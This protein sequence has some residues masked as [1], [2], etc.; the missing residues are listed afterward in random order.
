MIRTIPLIQS[1]VKE[2]MRDWKSILLLVVLPLVLISLVFVSFNPRGLQKI[3]VGL[4]VTDKTLNTGEFR[5]VANSF[6]ITTDFDDMDTCLLSLKRYEQYACI[7][8][9]KKGAI[10]LDVY[11]DNTREPVIWELLG[12]LKEATDLIKEG[13]SKNMASDFLA[14]FNENLEKIKVFKQN[15]QETNDLLDN[16]IGQ[17]DIVKSQMTSARN[18]LTNTLNEMDSDIN[19]VKSQEND[20]R[21]QKND[22]YSRSISTINQAYQYTFMFYN[23]T[24]SEYNYMYLMRNNLDDARNEI[25]DYNMAV[26]GKFAEVDTKVGKYE[27][28]SAQGRQYVYKLDQGISQVEVV[29]SD[30][31]NYQT[32]VRNAEGE[33]D[34][35]Y[36]DFAVVKD[37][38][39][40]VL[41]NP[42]V[43]RNTPTY[44]PEVSAELQKKFENEEG[45]TYEKIVKGLNMI[46]LQTLFPTLVIL[47]TLFLS[48]LISNYICLHEINSPSKTRIRLVKG[49]FFH[50][51]LSVFFSSLIIL[52]VPLLCILLLG[53]FLFL[54]PIFAN[55]VLVALVLGLLC[56]T[57]ILIGMGLAYLIKHES[58]ALLVSTFLLVL[59]IF[60]SGF[61]LPIERMSD[62]A[63]T[64]ANLFPGNIARS[65][66]NKVIFYGRGYWS[67]SYEVSVLLIWL[68]ILALLVLFVKKVRNL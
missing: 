66:I 14:K 3:P 25:N 17:A 22:M 58:L 52:F 1:S 9:V 51:F 11:Y 57:F 37:L 2:F 42:I 32:K 7:N 61:L 41:V 47:I 6:M 39:P 35:I 62:A 49:I 30:L 16:Y 13:Y 45:S 56:G 5:D 31:K 40:E 43:M 26:E 54:L 63:A 8:V 10:V 60:Y 44:I 50:E 28:A 20:I 48:L 18:D 33:L 4:V 27:Q 34:K 38:D 36:S 68:V 24:P 55:F 29:K 65:A 15:M 67:I 21:I 19:E 23:L 12:R 64:T 59:M 46:S 53:N